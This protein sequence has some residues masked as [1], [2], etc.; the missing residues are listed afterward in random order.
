MLKIVQKTMFWGYLIVAK[1]DFG[2]VVG[3]CSVCTINM[4]DASG[5]EPAIWPC[6]VKGCPYEDEKNQHAHHILSM[7]HLL[8]QGLDR[9]TFDGIRSSTYN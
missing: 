7:V 6:N 9:L 1:K 3:K 8:V 4:W 2:E 5:G